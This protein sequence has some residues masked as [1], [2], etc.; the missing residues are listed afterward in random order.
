MKVNRL[1]WSLT[2]TLL[3]LSMRVEAQT[4][5]PANREYGRTTLIKKTSV[6]TPGKPVA[7]SVR[8]YGTQSLTKASSNSNDSDYHSYVD[9]LERKLSTVQGPQKFLGQVVVSFLVN[10]NGMVTDAKIVKSSQMPQID[11]SALAA[12][13]AAGP[14]GVMPKYRTKPV[15]VELTFDGTS[16]STTAH[17]SVKNP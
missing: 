13:K 14:F 10:K 3:C 2:L 9:N 12:A 17:G 4:A 16:S 5:N 11:T 8:E 15:T 7:D 1:I 6:P